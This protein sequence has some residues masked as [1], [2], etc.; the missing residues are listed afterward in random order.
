MVETASLMPGPIRQGELPASLL[1]RITA[2]HEAINEVL[3]LSLS[4]RVE[5]FQRDVHP[6]HEVEIWERIVSAYRTLT[7]GTTSRT[8]SKRAAMS[9]LVGLSMGMRQA[10]ILEQQPELDPS[11]VN[12]AVAALANTAGRPNDS[13]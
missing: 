4:D 5:D 9:V 7:A 2:I 12:L 8:L 1:S 13:V 6:E 11:M 10:D 3:P